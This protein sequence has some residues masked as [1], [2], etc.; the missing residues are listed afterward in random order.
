MEVEYELPPHSQEEAEKGPRKVIFQSNDTSGQSGTI[1][2]SLYPTF[3]LSKET[4]GYDKQFVKKFNNVN[5]F[6]I[7]IRLKLSEER[8]SEEQSCEEFTFN[9]D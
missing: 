9:F 5:N 7:T 8:E 6:V 3:N 1:G 2:T 4:M